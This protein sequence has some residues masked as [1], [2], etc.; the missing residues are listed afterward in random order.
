V[1]PNP[2]FEARKRA[3]DILTGLGYTEV[4]GASFF[5]P[6]KASPRGEKCHVISNPVR[7]D[8]PA[9]RTSLLPSLLAASLANQNA[10]R[11]G[12]RVF[13]V[14][15]VCP[16]GSEEAV[17]RLAILD[18]GAAGE[19]GEVAFLRV[20]GAFEELAGSF[21]GTCEGSVEILSPEVASRWGIKTTPAILEVD[22]AAL[23]GEGIPIRGA[24]P[25]PRFPGIARDVALVLKEET[26]WA[27]I[28]K[29]VRELAHEWRTGP[30]LLGAPFRGEQ[31]GA[32]KKSIALRV[33]Y[34]A[35]DRTLTDEDVKGPHDEF[36][37]KL[38][39]ALGATLRQ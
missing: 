19:S 4:V 9:L 18:D 16:P 20:K 1:R 24:K 39:D 32:G 7:A 3:R 8:E 36:V 28:E 12:V 34:R 11:S 15:P 29:R 2:I 31:I 13:E 35:P 5:V 26:S 17:E 21:G 6:E 38:C 22:F 14:A 23:A 25:I 37:R 27:E 33:T 30:D 10:G